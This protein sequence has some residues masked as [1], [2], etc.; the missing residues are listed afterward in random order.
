MP[1]VTP[2]AVESSAQFR[3]GPP[4]A[5]TSQ[6]YAAAFNEAKALGSVNSSTR[7]ADQTQ[8]GMLWRVPLTNHQVWNR[9]A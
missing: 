5:L 4:P 1:N 3:P 9:I 8:V 2:F 6:E 7:T